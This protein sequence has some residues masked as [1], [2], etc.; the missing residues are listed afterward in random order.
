MG[1]DTKYGLTGI[2]DPT[3]ENGQLF[4]AT[5]V[6]LMAKLGASVHQW[7]EAQDTMFKQLES[8]KVE[9]GLYNRNSD[10]VDR[11]VMSHDNLQGIMVWSKVCNTFHKFDI[12]DYLVKH[13]GTYDNTKGKSPQLSRLLPFNPANFFIW[14]L[15]AEKKWTYIF[16]PFYMISLYITCNKPKEDTSGKILDWLG[17]YFNNE[18]FLVD[19]LFAYY[20][21]KMKEQYGENYLKELMNIYH[22]NQGESFE[23]LQLVNAKL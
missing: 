21:K 11:R 12:W 6:V 10:L 23:I 7:V 3:S 13:L 5:Y 2:Q 16:L 8:C 18:H 9:K 22:G 14:G 17:L 19:K 1:L 20:E 15:C 4:L